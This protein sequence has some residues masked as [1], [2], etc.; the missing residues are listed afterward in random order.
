MKPKTLFLCLI[1]LVGVFSS[2]FAGYLS[3]V[4][5]RREEP[6]L[7]PFATENKNAPELFSISS[8]SAAEKSVETFKE[9]YILRANENKVSLFIRYSNGDEQIHSEYDIPVNLLPKND[10]ERLYEG[11]EFDS[12]DEVMALIEDYLE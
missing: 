5:A 12:V 6:P 7:T 8:N 3:G 9:T 4:N 11:M 1:L 10:R 2:S